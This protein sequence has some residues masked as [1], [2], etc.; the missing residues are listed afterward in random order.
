MVACLNVVNIWFVFP[1]L[2]LEFA[3]LHVVI[4]FSHKGSSL[5]HFVTL[6]FFAQGIRV[7]SF[8][9]ALCDIFPDSPSSSHLYI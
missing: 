8:I 4:N 2:E 6:S 9:L 1:M 7:D 5:N 3:F